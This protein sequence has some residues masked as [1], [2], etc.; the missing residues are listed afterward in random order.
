MKLTPPDLTVKTTK[1]DLTVFT[2]YLG[3]CRSTGITDTISALQMYS[4]KTLLEKCFKLC[5]KYLLKKADHKVNLKVNEAER[6]LLS[7]L[8]K[9]EPIPAGISYMEF[10]IINNLTLQR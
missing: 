6:I 7:I 5:F 8:F 3:H 9:S 2:N 10:T 4:Y 1:E